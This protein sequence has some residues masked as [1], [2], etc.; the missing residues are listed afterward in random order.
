MKLI[1]FIFLTFL[2]IL[3]ANIICMFL[4]KVFLI[5]HATSLKSKFKTELNYL[6]GYK[7]IREFINKVLYWNTFTERR[8]IILIN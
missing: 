6:K 7:L 3:Q 8:K 1:L 2:K 4:R 5:K